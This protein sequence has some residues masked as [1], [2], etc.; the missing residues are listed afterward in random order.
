L[1]GNQ[2]EQE[3]LREFIGI[4]TRGSKS[5]TYKFALARAILD[6]CK[7]NDGFIRECILSGRQIQIDYAY[8][9]EYFIKCYWYQEKFRIRQ[10]F[11]P[12]K[13][14]NIIQILREEFFSRQSQPANYDEVPTELKQHAREKV[15]RQ[16]F[17]KE[18]N[19]TSQVVPR[20][21]N[22]RHGNKSV[23]KEIFYINDEKNHRILFR[24]TAMEF[25]AR[26]RVILDKFV[27]LEW[28]KFL[29][30]IRSTPGIVSKIEEPRFDRRSLQPS[31]KILEKFFYNCFYCGCSFEH[32]KIVMHVDH[33]IPFSFL[34][35]NELWN[36]VLACKNCNCNKSDSLPLEF[37]DLL[38]ARN[39]SFRKK[40]APLDYS[41]RKLDNGN[42]WETEMNRLYSSCALDFGFSEIKK[43][44]IL[45]T[46]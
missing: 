4:I 16:V 15:L 1:A 18:K 33:F 39:N 22:I 14:P 13:L 12:A 25:F 38:V 10:N 11:D 20:F 21:Q 26:Y 43:E 6:F 7:N 3:L 34:F 29:E 17:G 45:K 41:L 2:E 24:P 28:A 23:K 8:L 35:N 36:L 30:N 32:P 37:K 31:Q 42:G 40:I 27:V 9:A 46:K 5:N 19:S 44:E